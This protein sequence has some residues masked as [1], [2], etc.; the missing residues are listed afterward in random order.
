MVCP[1]G[2][3]SLGDNALGGAGGRFGSLISRPSADS[4]A[5]AVG[6]SG[7]GVLMCFGSGA[8]SGLPVFRSSDGCL[9]GP[10]GSRSLMGVTSGSFRGSFTC[11][12][13]PPQAG[14]TTVA[15]AARTR[16]RI[17]ARRTGSMAMTVEDTHN[18]SSYKRKI[19]MSGQLYRFERRG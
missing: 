4:P 7:A 12:G 3:R 10:S 8:L 6:E 11:S 17:R 14:I 2:G 19:G 15:A 18:P 16:A 13:T 9:E 1:G 5:A